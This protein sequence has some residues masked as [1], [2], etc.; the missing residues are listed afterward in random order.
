MAVPV[1]SVVSAIRESLT[2][3]R[4]SASNKLMETPYY[5]VLIICAE[6]SIGNSDHDMLPC[7]VRVC[8]GGRRLL[9]VGWIRSP[10]D[11]PLGTGCTK[12][13]RC[14]SVLHRGG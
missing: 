11:W 2:L 6:G 3:L 7:F 4:A 13:P 1:I 8:T 14:R 5:A 10:I 9:L 12:A